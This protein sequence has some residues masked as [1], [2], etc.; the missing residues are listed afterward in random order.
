MDV[1]FVGQ[2]LGERMT[3]EES[4]GIQKVIMDDSVGSPVRDRGCWFEFAGD[5]HLPDNPAYPLCHRDS[6]RP[7]AAGRI[8][9]VSWNSRIYMEVKYASF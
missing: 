5:I 4:I 6:Q 1:S 2:P 8:K 9:N 3:N 7:S